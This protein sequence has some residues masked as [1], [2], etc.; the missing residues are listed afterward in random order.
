MTIYVDDWM[1]P[2]RVGRL[3]AK[4]SHLT[5]GPFDDIGELHDFAAKIGLQRRWYQDKPWPRQHYD[6]TESKRQA[7]I[8]AGAVAITWRETGQH[9][10]RARQAQKNASRQLV[11]TRGGVRRPPSDDE[12]WPVAKALYELASMKESASADGP[13]PE[14]EVLF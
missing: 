6:V 5:V 11:C 7:A 14:S 8:A 2:A 9:I 1:Q 3:S 4:W 10:T 12:L 13:D